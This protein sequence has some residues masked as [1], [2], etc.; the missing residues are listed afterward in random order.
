M[1]EMAPGGHELVE[2]IVA[3]VVVV[4]GTIFTVI[5]FLTN[6]AR[7]GP[8][9]SAPGRPDRIRRPRRRSGGPSP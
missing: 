9:A 2:T 5:T 4:G 6:P 8:G 3:V 1:I 7:R